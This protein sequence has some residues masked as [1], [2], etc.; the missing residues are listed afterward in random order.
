MRFYR[1]GPARLHISHT[2]KEDYLFALC[3]AAGLSNDRLQPVSSPFPLET[4]VYFYYVG[5]IFFALVSMTFPAWPDHTALW[6]RHP[7]LVTLFWVVPGGAV[8]TPLPTFSCGGAQYRG[9]LFPLGGQAA[10]LRF[11]L[12][13]PGHAGAAA[14]VNLPWISRWLTGRQVYSLALAGPG[15]GIVS[16]APRLRGARYFLLPGG[17]WPWPWSFSS[18]RS[19]G[20]MQGEYWARNSLLVGTALESILLSWPLRARASGS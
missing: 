4:G 15:A 7:G 12:G 8:H 6:D 11:G 20:P 14:V 2:V 3:Y 1:L 17:C 10:H 16:P 18:F 9:R 5:Y 13:T 19:W